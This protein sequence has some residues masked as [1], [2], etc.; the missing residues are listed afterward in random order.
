MRA[1]RRSIPIASRRRHDPQLCVNVYKKTMIKNFFA[2][3]LLSAAVN[4][5]PAQNLRVQRDS[6]WTKAVDQVV[7]AACGR[8]IAVLGES[9][10]HAFGKTLEFKVDVASRLITQ[11]GYRAF[12]VES[13]IY[14]FLRFES[15]LAAGRAVT[16]RDVA[17][18]IGGIWGYREMAPLVS[19]LR[20]RANARALAVGGIDDQVGRGSYA[21][22]AMPAD[23]VAPLEPATRSRCLAA[24]ERHM[25]WQYTAESPYAPVHRTEMLDCLDAID[26][27]GATGAAN[28]RR[29][30]TD[31]LRR[32]LGRDFASGPVGAAETFSARDRSMYENFRALESRLAPGTKIILWTATIHA[33]KSLAGVS[34]LERQ[35]P[36]GAS[37]QQQFPGEVFVL[38]FSAAGGTFAMGRQQPRVLTPAPSSS[39]EAL[40]LS[41]AS[42]AVGFLTAMELRRIGAAP[43]RLLGAEFKTSQWSDVV[44]GVVVFREERPP[45]PT[46]P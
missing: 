11:C 26:R 19:L 28:S 44:D 38:G 40:A 45:L 23:L 37:V 13:G 9:P 10:L 8:R 12:F 41:D 2:L 22:S 25:K 30:M 20:E 1:I 17:A 24:F 35:T 7:A 33:A 39:I 14:D 31:N 4:R 3:A 34:G 32:F 29:L 16:E 42:A 43:G 18:A 46:I 15:E 6:G 36:L 5:L 21:Q 27:A